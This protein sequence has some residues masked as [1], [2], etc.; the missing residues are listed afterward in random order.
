MQVTA[1]AVNTG[2]CRRTGARWRRPQPVLIGEP[3]SRI[4]RSSD[5]WDP[6]RPASA[7][8]RERQP[9]HLTV[10][11]HGELGQRTD[12]VHDQQRP[13][14]RQRDPRAVRATASSSTR[15]PRPLRTRR[16]D[17]ASS[18]DPMS[19]SPPGDVADP[20]NRSCPATCQP[21]RTPS[22]GDHAGG[23]SRCTS[24]CTVPRTSTT[25]SRPVRSGRRPEVAR[26]TGCAEPWRSGARAHSRR[27]AVRRG[28]HQHSW[29]AHW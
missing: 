13:S 1:V 10:G 11:T 9:G 20:H 8:R 29:P 17:P 15:R 23:P 4:R 18:S 24:R 21:S 28:I 19:P 26:R 14:C 22:R 27:R 5:S 2:W 3:A 6:T 7:V 16:L 25:L 12:R